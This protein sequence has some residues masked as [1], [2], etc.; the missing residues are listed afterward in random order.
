VSRQPSPAPEQDLAAFP[1][2]VLELGSDVF[3]SHRPDLGPCFFNG[4]PDF[5]FNLLSGR[6]TCY[7]GDDVATAVREKLREHV[8]SQGVVP[9]SLAKTFVVSTIRTTRSFTCADIG[10]SDA[11][12][13]NVSRMLATMDDYGIPQQWAAAFDGAGFEG[14]RYGSSF[15]N[16]PANAWALFDAAGEHPF[17]DTVASYSGVVACAIAGI[18]VYQVPHSDELDTV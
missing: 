3:R 16:G 6:G 10:D 1:V 17:G 18:Q 12:E 11:V 4:S 7:V 14:V 15:T 8:L 9:V 5:R 2:D 13:H